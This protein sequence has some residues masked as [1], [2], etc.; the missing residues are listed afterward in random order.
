MDRYRPRQPDPWGSVVP[1]SHRVS[2]SECQFDLG[3]QLAL[4]RRWE[5]R[6][7]AVGFGAGVQAD[8]LTVGS[9][10]NGPFPAVGLVNVG[11]FVRCELGF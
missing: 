8:V 4:V 7:R 10:G 5:W 6:G 3:L 1:W 9:L 11:P 2:V